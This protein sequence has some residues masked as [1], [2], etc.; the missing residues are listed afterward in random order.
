MD[1]A[2]KDTNGLFVFDLPGGRVV[3]LENDAKLYN[4]LTWNE[5][6]TAVAVLKGLDVDKMRERNNV[7]VVYPNVRASV[8]AHGPG[9]AARHARS[10]QGRRHSRKAGW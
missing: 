3:P 2:V 9:A 5:S 4:R 1:A 10:R 8:D 6:G 7:L